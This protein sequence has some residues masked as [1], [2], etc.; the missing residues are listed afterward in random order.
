VVVGDATYETPA[1]LLQIF[2]HAAIEPLFTPMP[3]AI[4]KTIPGFRIVEGQELS[5]CRK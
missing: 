4:S 1:Q 3:L 5:A 2:F